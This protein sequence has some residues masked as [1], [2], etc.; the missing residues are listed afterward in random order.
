M[1]SIKKRNIAIV[2][3]VIT[4][5]VIVIATAVVFA[6][7]QEKDSPHGCVLSTYENSVA[8]YIDGELEEV[9]SEI[10]LDTL[11]PQDIKQL[12]YGIAFDTVEE[13]QRAIEDYDG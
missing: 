8:L 4:L 11:P 12:E 2:A 5:A 1:Q 3:I 7:G 10:V 9:Y 13:A 6:S